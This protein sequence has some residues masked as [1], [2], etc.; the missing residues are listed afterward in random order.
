MILQVIDI[1]QTFREISLALYAILIVIELRIGVYFLN[2]YRKNKELGFIGAIGLFFLFFLA[3]RVILVIFDYYLVNMDPALYVT[4]FTQYKFATGLQAIG[5]GFFLYV[6][7]RA[8]FQGKDKYV[9]II[10][11]SIFSILAAVLPD[12]NLS[13]TMTTV[14]TFFIIFIPLSYIYT[15]IKGKGPI[16]TQ[17]LLLVTGVILFAV[18]ALLIGEAVMSSLRVV[19]G[20][21]YPVHIISIIMK[22]V[23]VI[24]VYKG[25]SLQIR[26]E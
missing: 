12:F 4:Y 1:V 2:A 13:Q 23:G 9:L 6:A 15:A 19:F 8:L 22:L 7:E 24:I 11:Y 5:L 3:G 14:A 17:S 18:G 10:G 20:S 26:R 25:F 16:R 21:P